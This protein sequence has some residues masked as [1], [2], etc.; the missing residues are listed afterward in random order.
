MMASTEKKSRGLRILA[1]A[2]AMMVASLWAVVANPGPAEASFPGTNGKIVFT[3]DVGG[4]G[5]N[6][7]IYIMSPNGTHKT[8][9]TKNP[10][11]DQDP[12]LSPNG[13]KI[14]FSSNRSGYYEIFTMNVDGTNQKR[15]PKYDPV[16]GVSP[17]FS[18]DGKKVAFVYD[19]EIFV[20]NADGSNLTRLTFGA[21]VDKSPAFSPDGTKIAFVSN[22]DGNYEIYTMKVSAENNTTN[23]PSRLTNDAAED[24][25]PSFSPDGTK[26]AFQSNRSG[27]YEI[28]TMPSNGLGVPTNLTKYGSTDWHPA[29]SPDGKQITFVSSR[30]ST[31]D[32]FVMNSDG[33]GWDHRT[34][35]VD[36][37]YPDWGPKP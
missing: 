37:F 7:E 6:L 34:S 21:H 16:A 36:N 15:L 10:A 31:F 3:S 20:I 18:P 9:L 14:V 12:V 35:G 27:N 30:Y 22:R 1:A 5:N 29:F 24:S 23:V 32:V 28:Y 19:N 11:V 26:I 2:A 17:T 25:Y 4:V 33:S 8:K 13:K